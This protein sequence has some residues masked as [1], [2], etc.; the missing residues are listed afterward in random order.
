MNKL[1]RRIIL[2]VFILS[3]VNSV[4]FAGNDPLPLWNPTKSK[5]SIIN[6]VS[7]VTNKNKASYIPPAERIA[8]F[9]RVIVESSV[10]VS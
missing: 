10:W 9:D 3:G 4:T 5:E 2:I 6:F 7:Q 8:V 1:Y